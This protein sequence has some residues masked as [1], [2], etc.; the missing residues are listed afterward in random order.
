MAAMAPEHPFRPTYTVPPGDTIA[1]LLEEHDMTQTELAR[2]LGVTL[3][4]VNQIVNGAAS[5]SAELALG[6]EKVFQAPAD[7]WL[8]RES[9]YR[10]D[11]ARQ[12]EAK[13]LESHLG[14]A[15]CFPLKDLKKRGFIPSNASGTELVDA[16]LRFLGIASPRQ[17]QDPAVAYRKSQH[18]ESDPFALA[19][20]LRAG[21]I[22]ASEIETAPFDHDRFMGTL[23]E[24]RTLTRLHPQQ[25][26]PRLVELLAESGVAVVV[27]DTFERARANGATR[28]LAPSKALIQLSLR[29]RWED[30]FW[31]TFFHEAGHIALHRKK[32]LFVEGLKVAE[33]KATAPQW[34]KLEDEANRFASQILI[35]E[36]HEYRLRSLTL[37]EIET[38]A[39]ELGVAPA[40]IVGRMQH[41]RIIEFSQWNHHRRRLTF[42]D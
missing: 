14:W 29:Y 13:E 30:V 18:Y 6:L 15:N 5:I 20:W 8:N 12:M 28:W 16:L 42:A 37:S 10:A 41:D 17:W 35:P 32:E 31:F 33:P 34:Q 3:K 19:A 25:W 2:R 40:V 22:E 39:D 27:I 38:F 1:D 11:V 7:F 24:A 26:H 9:L 4:H 36:S 21:E 23:A